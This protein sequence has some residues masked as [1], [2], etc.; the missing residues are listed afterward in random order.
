MF[1]SDKNKTT[2]SDNF[3]SDSESEE[4]LEQEYW[5]HFLLVEGTSEEKPLSKLS[6]FAIERGFR[7]IVSEKLKSIKK[8]R[9]GAFLVEVSTLKQS[10]RLRKAT[11]FIDRPIRVTPH[12][13]LNS[14]K[15]VIKCPELK[16]TSELEMKKEMKKQGVTDVYKCKVKRNGIEMHTGTVF[17]TF[18]T[19]V[20]PESL[21]VGYIRCAVTPYIPSP[22]RCF[23]CQKFGHTRMRC[24]E[25]ERCADCS[26]VRHDD[27]CSG[28]HLCIN[29]GG[30]HSASSK[31]CPQWMFECQVQQVKTEKRVSFYEA[32]KIVKERQ[33]VIRSG[34]S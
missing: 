25:Q 3:D 22:M 13:T 19:P 17:V 16:E 23:K 21:T 5:P 20:L 29:C 31:E 4:L 8:L 11:I 24:S 33:P 30:A 1:N 12:K 28:P 9:S 26:F 10:L 15:G 34:F 14:S 18:R 7:G 2:E 32:K 27:P 6:P